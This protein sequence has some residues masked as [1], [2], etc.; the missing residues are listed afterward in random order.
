MSK[1]KNS[2]QGF[3]RLRWK[4]DRPVWGP[5]THTLSRGGDWL[6]IVQ[7]C[8]DGWFWYGGGKN[9]SKSPTDLE[10]AKAEAKKHIQQLEANAT[11]QG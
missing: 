2:I 4:R 9:T 1:T 11:D 6:A 5:E 7:E 3:V 8:G 10:T